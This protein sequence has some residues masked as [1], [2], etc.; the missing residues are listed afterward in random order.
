M[1]FLTRKRKGAMRETFGL[2]STVNLQYA[3]LQS[4][5]G[6]KIERKKKRERE[7]RRLERKLT[8]PSL[9]FFD[10]NFIATSR[11]FTDKFVPAPNNECQFSGLPGSDEATP[12][13]EIRQDTK[14][15]RQSKRSRQLNNYSSLSFSYSSL[16]F[17]FPLSLSFFFS[18][19]TA[20]LSF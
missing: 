11:L 9:F 18:V 6:R 3:P 2:E 8:I 1:S 10:V 19:L 13:T 17:C 20:S 15:R 7:A 12:K 5:E 4:K 14:R 16:S